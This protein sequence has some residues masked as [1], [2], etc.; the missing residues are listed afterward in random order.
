MLIFHAGETS[1]CK[2]ERIKSKCETKKPYLSL[3]KSGAHTL[4]HTQWVMHE[5]SSNTIYLSESCQLF[6]MLSSR[7][8]KKARGS[9]G[10]ARQK[11]RTNSNAQTSVQARISDR[12]QTPSAQ[13]LLA[14]GHLAD[15]AAFTITLSLATWWWCKK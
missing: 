5:T 4:M 10:E 9:G 13:S 12:A 14:K 8:F 6:V 7:P 11:H 1:A 3:R 2:R 15:V